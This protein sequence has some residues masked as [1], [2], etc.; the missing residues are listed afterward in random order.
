MTYDPCYAYELAVIVHGG[1]RR[2][3]DENEN[4]FYYI[5]VM[6]E[7]YQQ[8]PMPEGVA[9]DILRGMYRLST[10]GEMSQARA[11]AW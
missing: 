11:S 10:L 2:M 6:N 7:S 9:D 4:V 3:V 8:P 5:T 1:L